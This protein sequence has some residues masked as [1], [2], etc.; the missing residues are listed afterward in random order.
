M[1]DFFIQKSE[2]GGR[3]EIPKKKYN[4]STCKVLLAL[5]SER[6]DMSNVYKP[7]IER[8]FKKKKHVPLLSGGAASF[9]IEDL[10]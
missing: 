1:C 8:D 10:V 3:M 6:Y 4:C 9:S 7:E 5:V 2:F